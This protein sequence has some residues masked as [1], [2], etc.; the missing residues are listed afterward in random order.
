M[1]QAPFDRVRLRHRRFSPRF[2]E[3]DFLFQE[4]AD[5]LLDRLADIRRDF[6]LAAEIGAGRGRLGRRLP[7]QHCLS[8]DLSPA[9]LKGCP[10]PV[11]ADEEFLPLAPGRFDLIASNLALHQVNDLPGALIQ[12]CRALRPDGLFLAALFG[13]GTLAELREVLVQAEAELTGRAAPRVAPVADVRDMGGLL[14]RAGFALPVADT[15]RITVDYG[16][17]LRLFTDLRAMGEGNM[18]RERAPLRRDVLARALALYA[19][20][21]GQGDGT[22]PVRFDIV[23]LTGWAPGPD[24]PQPLKPGSAGT[25]LADALGTR[26]VPLPRK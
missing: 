3:A 7:V 5:R 24:Q 16:D 12:S 21:H 4:V 17:L 6:T 19:A 10:G 1:S 22:V 25:R 13:G 20:R 18:L 9:L 23:Y 26:E 15:D 8:L 14:Q 11:V 2:A